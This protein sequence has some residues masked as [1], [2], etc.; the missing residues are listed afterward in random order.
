MEEAAA[1]QFDLGGAAAVRHRSADACLSSGGVPEQ[2]ALQAAEACEEAYPTLE[3]DV[4]RVYDGIEQATDER[5]K[6]LEERA[7]AS[8]RRQVDMARRSPA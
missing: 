1:L 5:R 3:E 4:A 2:A 7:V 6:E 8:A